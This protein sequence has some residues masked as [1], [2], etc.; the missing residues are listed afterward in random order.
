MR[1]L[2]PTDGT[3]AHKRAGRY[4][5]TTVKTGNTKLHADLHEEMA[6]KLADLTTKARAHEDAEEDA[7]AASA[8]SDAAEITLENVIRDMDG[9]LA[10]LDREDPTLNARATV[11]PDGYGKEI[12]PEGESQLTTL[13]ALRDR[14]AKFGGHPICAAILTK[15]DAARAAFEQAI[16]AEQAAEDLADAAFRAEVDARRIV[17][18]QLESAYGRLR[19]L[20]KARPAVT[21]TFFLKEGRRRALKEPTG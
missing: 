21:E 14:L 10:K 18:E 7:V 2:R 16:K 19:D 8:A 6:L 9:D 5:C 4:H 20:Y 1:R 11:F 13:G 15:F 17:R 3:P 12:D